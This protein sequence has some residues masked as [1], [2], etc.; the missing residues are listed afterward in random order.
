MLDEID[1]VRPDEIEKKSFAII[2]DLLGERTFP[3]EQE[4]VVKRVIHATADLE[5]ADLMTFRY[6]AVRKA[7]DAIRQGCHIVTD[8]QMAASGISKKTL[9]RWSGEVHCLIG[10]ASV[11][12]EAK[13]RQITRSAVCTERYASDTRNAVFVIGNAP[14]ALIRLAELIRDGMVHPQCVIGVPVGFVNVVESK[15]CILKTNV[16]CIVATGRKGGSTVA[17][18]IVNAILYMMCDGLL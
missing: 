11:A 7:A 10:D 4:P 3:S 6:D 9:S 13:A 14:T 2:S 18:A 15:E 17:A 8:T 16:P 5:F 12:K 1:I